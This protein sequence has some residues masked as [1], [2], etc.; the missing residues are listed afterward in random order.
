MINLKFWAVIT[1]AS[2]ILIPIFGILYVWNNSVI[3]W[4]L[5]V[6]DIII[7]FFA[8]AMYSLLKK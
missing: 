1:G 6:T 7:F 5:L 4:R 2:F 8:V 3:N